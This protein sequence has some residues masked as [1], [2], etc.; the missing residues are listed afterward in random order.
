M[1]RLYGPLVHATTWKQTLHLL[2]DLP[3]GITFFT[4]AIT[5][6]SVSAGL[7][8][9]VV[10]L[11]LLALTVFAGRVI[12]AI[13]RGRATLLL[14]TVVD[15]PA[16]LDTSGGPWAATKRAISD[17]AGWKGLGYGVLMLPWGIVAFTLSV[18][19]WSLALSLPLSPVFTVLELG[20]DEPDFIARNR[21]AL[22]VAAVIV[23]LV[24]L[25]VT[26]RAVNGLAA[27]DKALVKALLGRSREGELVQRVEELS[28]SRDAS[29][30]G[31][32][33]ELRRIE[34]DLHD[35]A[36]QRL[37]ALAMELGLAKERL[38]RDQDPARALESVN[39]AHDEAKDAIV[40]LRELVRGIHPSVL[41]DRGLDAALSAV[42]A[43][44]PV[45]VRLDVDLPERPPAAV[46][47]AAYF[48]VTEALANVAKHSRATRASVRV[49]R[50]AG[51]LVVEVF[52]DGVGGA[53]E[54]P[55]GGLSG[56]RDRVLAVEGKLRLASPP[57]GPTT[58]VAELPCG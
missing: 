28:V 51:H 54:H 55:G 53:S 41:T 23:G 50:V 5:M 25:A 12:S 33:A 43:R 57:G 4:V 49:D 16:P 26:P 40:E 34:R 2:L 39:R 13:D 8:V 22:T 10:G 18:T 17:G 38:E 9:L 58:L 37:V 31:S 42:A 56:L 35:G 24:L 36:Q 21:A 19:L 44:S 27:I 52:D 29:V 3:A 47:A 14:D 20:N 11:P 48:V 15:G 7:M 46:E 30:E 1:R 45:P 6:L 32:A